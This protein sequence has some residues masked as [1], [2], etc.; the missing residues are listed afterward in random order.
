MWPGHQS[1]KRFVRWSCR[2][3]QQRVGRG[4]H[5]AGRMITRTGTELFSHIAT[6]GHNVTTSFS[7]TAGAHQM[8]Q[9]QVEEPKIA[10]DS[11]SSS[12]QCYD[13]WQNFICLC[14][15]YLRDRKRNCHNSQYT[16]EPHLQQHL[17][18]Q[19][20]MFTKET[21]NV[22]RNRIERRFNLSFILRTGR[23]KV[24]FVSAVIIW[25]LM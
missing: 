22:Q 15:G 1:K 19:P 14:H 7:K 10:F 12:V 16:G 13:S 25:A 21:R 4:L 6:K 18:F 11:S 24:K 23:W 20:P 17:K 2:C 5:K 8:E 3:D 9:T